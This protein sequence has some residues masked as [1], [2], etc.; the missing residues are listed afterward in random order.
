MAVIAVGV[1]VLAAVLLL[2]DGSSPAA[3]GPV[4]FHGS[5]ALSGEFH[6]RETYTDASTGKKARS[7]AA[8]GAHGDRP[9]M[10]PDT[11]IVPTPPINNTVEIEI[12]T[13]VRGY[14]GPGRYGQATLTEGNGAMDVG[15]E[16]YDLTSPDGK[17]SMT[18]KADGSGSVTFAHVPGDDD[19][20]HPGWHGGISGTIAWSCTS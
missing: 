18:V 20:P 11:W 5:V 3:V 13:A 15:P 7:C 10:G 4:V 17:A 9:S 16:S 1:A 2:G 8:A 6:T 12:G 14:R 19:N